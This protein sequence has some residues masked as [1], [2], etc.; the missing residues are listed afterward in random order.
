MIRLAVLCWLC[1][2]SMAR[3]RRGEQSCCILLSQQ[4]LD[5]WWLQ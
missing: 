1:C 2:L 5:Q 4:L 3:Q